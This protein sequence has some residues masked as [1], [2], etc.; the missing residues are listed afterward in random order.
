MHQ[1][2]PN[3]FQYHWIPD[4]VGRRRHIRLLGYKPFRGQG[5]ACV[6]EQQFSFAVTESEFRA[7]WGQITPSFHLYRLELVSV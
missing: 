2:G 4:A 7:S 6:F 1:L 5:N 3:S